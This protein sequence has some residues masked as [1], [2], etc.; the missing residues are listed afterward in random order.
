MISLIYMIIADFL[1]QSR[2]ELIESMMYIQ[3]RVVPRLILYN[4]ISDDHINHPAGTPDVR[5]AHKSM[6]LRY[7]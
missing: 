5:K 7:H 4:F 2:F 6:L 1:F 3:V